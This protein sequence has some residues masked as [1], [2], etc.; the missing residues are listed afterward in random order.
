[1]NSEKGVL[2]QSNDKLNQKLKNKKHFDYYDKKMKQFDMLGDRRQS[3]YSKV[4][5][6]NND[7]DNPE[8]RQNKKQL[9]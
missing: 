1:M 3:K 9:G 8:V 6:L 5:E 7:S 4:M 2:N